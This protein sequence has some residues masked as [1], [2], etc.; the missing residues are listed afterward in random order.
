MKN[1]GQE[2]LEQKNALGYIY[3]SFYFENNDWR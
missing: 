2:I 1:S 3:D